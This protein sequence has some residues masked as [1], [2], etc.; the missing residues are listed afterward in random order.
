M[1]ITIQFPLKSGIKK[2]KAASKAVICTAQ[3]SQ[4]LGLPR[5]CTG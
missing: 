4:I 3:H 2:K 5:L 1:G